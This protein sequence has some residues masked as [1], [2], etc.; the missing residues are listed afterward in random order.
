M[1][2]RR[3]H[4]LTKKRNIALLIVGVILLVIVAVVAVRV[5][6]PSEVTVTEGVDTTVQQPQPEVTTPETT[7]PAPSEDAN[8]VTVPAEDI[9][10]VV[11][12]PMNIEVSYVKSGEGFAYAVSRTAAGT[13]FVDFTSETLIGTRCTDDEGIFASI[14]ENPSEAE[15]ATLSKTTTID[16]VSYGLSLV[17]ANCTGNPERLAQFQASFSDVFSLLARP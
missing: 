10:T 3:T 9:A 12:E 11:I 16:G 15:A 1:S 4:Q 8:A 14:I 7:E 17:T 13:R 2:R 6:T 5:F